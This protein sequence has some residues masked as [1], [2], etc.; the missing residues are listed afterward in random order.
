MTGYESC[1]ACGKK[2]AKD[3]NYMIMFGDK[4]GNTSDSDA[5][6]TCYNKVYKMFNHS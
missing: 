1:D 3:Q 2:L 5:C 4:Y 6:V